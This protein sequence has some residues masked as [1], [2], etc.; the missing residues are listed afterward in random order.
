MIINSLSKGIWVQSLKIEYGK[1][2]GTGKKV[3]A[4]RVILTDGFSD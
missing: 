2:L 1:F 4:R 3:G